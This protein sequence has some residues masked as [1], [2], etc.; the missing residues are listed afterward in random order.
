MARKVG[1]QPKPADPAA[2]TPRER[3]L[4]KIW[5]LRVK[6]IE[7]RAREDELEKLLND[8]VV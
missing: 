2:P 4:V 3:V 1:P 7:L 8:K 6:V 5:D